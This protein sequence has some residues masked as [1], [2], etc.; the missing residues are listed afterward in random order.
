MSS[1]TSR[2][3]SSADWSP[4]GLRDAHPPC[5]IARITEEFGTLLTQLDVE[6]GD[7]VGLGLARAGQRDPEG[8]VP[9]G[10]LARRRLG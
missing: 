5:L 7:V 4:K 1:P 10:P 3:I 9:R 8:G 6:G 2:G